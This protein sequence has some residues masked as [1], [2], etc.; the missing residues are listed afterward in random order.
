MKFL[1]LSIVLF[2]ISSFAQDSAPSSVP[3]I[4]EWDIVEVSSQSSVADFVSRNPGDVEKL[5]Q[6]LNCRNLEGN[7]CSV[8]FKITKS[9]NDDGPLVAT[10]ESVPGVFNTLEGRIRTSINDSLTGGKGHPAIEPMNALLKTADM[11][12]KNKS[13]TARLVFEDDRGTVILQGHIV[14]QEFQGTIAYNTYGDGTVEKASAGTLG[15]FVTDICSVFACK[16]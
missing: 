1:A 10:T 2:S 3:R 6:V 9:L 14:G 11:T 5:G 7:P 13:G 16:K 8:G 12:Y 4:E 15:T